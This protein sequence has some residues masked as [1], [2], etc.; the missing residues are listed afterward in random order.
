[1]NYKMNE[2]WVKKPNKQEIVISLLSKLNSIFDGMDCT[3]DCPYHAY[4]DK[5]ANMTLCTVITMALSDL[6]R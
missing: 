1:M 4:C 3:L 2:V 6:N 5:H